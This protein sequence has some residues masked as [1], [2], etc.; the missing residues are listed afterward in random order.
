MKKGQKKDLTQ[1]SLTRQTLDSGHKI[2]I[3]S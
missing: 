1:P 2:E 3:T